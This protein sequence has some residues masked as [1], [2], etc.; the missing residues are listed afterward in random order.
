MYVYIYLYRSNNIIY[1]NCLIPHT[2]MKYLFRSNAK[3]LVIYFVSVPT[4]ANK[5]L[6]TGSYMNAYFDP[7][8]CL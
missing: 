2:R 1:E 5:I 4:K 7:Q 6:D 8:H 3:L